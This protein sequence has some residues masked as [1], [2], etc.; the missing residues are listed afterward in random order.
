MYKEQQGEA[1]QPP[2]QRGGRIEV[3]V[4]GCGM[5]EEEDLGSLLVG[6]L[7]GLD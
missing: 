1:S 5:R 2:G 6:E 7:G 3:Q 4:L